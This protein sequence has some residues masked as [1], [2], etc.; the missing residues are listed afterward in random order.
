MPDRTTLSPKAL[1]KL[2][3]RAENN[4]YG[5][6][7]RF[8]SNFKSADRMGYKKPVNRQAS[9]EISYKRSEKP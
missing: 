7:A 9:K 4:S 6:D 5:K 3:R 2:R 1:R 8:W